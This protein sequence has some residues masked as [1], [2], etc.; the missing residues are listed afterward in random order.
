M[1]LGDGNKTC[2]YLKGIQGLSN[3]Q[4]A[5]EDQKKDAFTKGWNSFE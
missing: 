3:S 4:D 5:Y 2:Y 1:G